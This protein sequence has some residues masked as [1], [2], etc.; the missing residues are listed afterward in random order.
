MK[1]ASL[2]EREQA[3]IAGYYCERDHKAPAPNL[4]H[5]NFVGPALN[6]VWVADITYI[7]EL[8]GGFSLPGGGARHFQPVHRGPGLATHLRSELVLEALNMALGQRRP[9]AVVYHSDQANQ[10]TSLV[11][12]KRCEQAWVWPA[13]AS[14]G[15]CFDNATFAKASLP[16][17]HANCSIAVDFSRSGRRW[18][19][20]P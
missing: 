2:R 18:T 1:A 12:G 5:R 16:P 17:S 9:A 7:S 6:P 13:I 14:L 8:G 19:A 4:L 10:Y 20:A 11:F 15:D 3:P